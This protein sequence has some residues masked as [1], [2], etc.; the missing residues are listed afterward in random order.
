V[1]FASGFAVSLPYA[2]NCRYVNGYDRRG[3]VV[4]QRSLAATTMQGGDGY[5]TLGYDLGTAVTAIHVR[6]APKVSVEFGQ[7]TAA[8]SNRLIASV[9]V[10]PKRTNAPRL[11]RGISVL[12]E[13]LAAG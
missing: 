11:P 8:K 3:I 6:N 10:R 5:I 13:G 9:N 7:D 4:S 12:V 1:M 2:P